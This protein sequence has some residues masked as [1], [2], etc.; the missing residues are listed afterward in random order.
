MVARSADTRAAASRVAKSLVDKGR[1]DDAVAVL[2]VWAVTGPNGQE[3]RGLLAEALRIDPASR[4][5]KLAF[6]RLE[7]IAGEH[8]LLE[9][10]IARWSADEVSRVDGEM[11]RR[12][13]VRAQVGFN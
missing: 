11:A 4:L 5:A 13:F 3:G 7:G 2:A 6:E 10:A 12:S 8:A 1:P 9:E